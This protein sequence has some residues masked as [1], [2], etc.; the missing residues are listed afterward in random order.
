MITR[1]LSIL[2]VATAKIISSIIYP[3]STNPH[4]SVV[5]IQKQLNILVQTG[6]IIRGAGWYALPEYEGSYLDHDRLLTSLIAR[7]IILKLPISVYREVSF[8]IGIRSDLVALIGK[9]GKALCVVI[10]ACNNETDEYLQMKLNLWKTW[11]GANR[12]LSELFQAN[13]PNFSV[14]ISRNQPDDGFSKLIGEL[15]CSN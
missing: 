2:K 5:Q 11:E 15:K 10:E 9:N 7:L 14:V 12:A 6:K 8:P 1:V 3:N 4:S 13:I